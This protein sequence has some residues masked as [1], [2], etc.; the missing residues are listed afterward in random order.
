M[1][2]MSQGVGNENANADS[3]KPM[4]RWPEADSPSGT[5]FEIFKVAN[6]LREELK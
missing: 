6:Y 2:C 1:R 3:E 5:L 4:H